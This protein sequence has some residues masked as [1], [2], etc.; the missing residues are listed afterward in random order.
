MSLL[1]RTSIVSA[2]TLASRVMG[3]ARD[4]ATA[5]VLGVGPVADALAAA[6]ALPLLA[7]RLLA[8]GAFNLAFIPALARTAN[9]AGGNR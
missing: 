4:A 9:G 2:A 8:E 7:R 6:M 3:F 5:A 1:A